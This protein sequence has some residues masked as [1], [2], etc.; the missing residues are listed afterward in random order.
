MTE[1]EKLMLDMLERLYIELHEHN[2]KVEFP[3]E[4]LESELGHLI[5]KIKGTTYDYKAA[6]RDR[7]KLKKKFGKPDSVKLKELQEA[8]KQFAAKE[9]GMITPDTFK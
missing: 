4:S 9:L 7:A 3:R 8:L 1:N 2:A 5:A 6:K